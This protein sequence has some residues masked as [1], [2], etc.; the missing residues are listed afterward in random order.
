MKMFSALGGL[1]LSGLGG[2]AI[3]S[4]FA[5]KEL[6]VEALRALFKRAIIMD[7]LSLGFEWDEVEYEALARTGLTGFHATLLNRMT[8]EGAVKDLT[9]WNFRIRENPDI[10][11]LALS[12]DDFTEAKKQDQVAVLLGFQDCA[13]LGR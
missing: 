1:S 10:F 12:P 6:G 11:R 9:A 5:Q 2:A 4:A 8:L 3:K 7:A 13:M